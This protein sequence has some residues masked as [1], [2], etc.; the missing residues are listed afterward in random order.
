MN[1]EYNNSAHAK[2]YGFLHYKV[3]VV[4]TDDGTHFPYFNHDNYIL[5]KGDDVNKRDDELYDMVIEDLKENYKKFNHIT[6]EEQLNDPAF[7][8]INISVK[9]E[10]F[11][12]R[13]IK[14]TK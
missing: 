9:K 3:T 5:L 1:I 11:C 14:I 10:T 12:S 7:E 2:I 13:S 4:Y 6:L 8:C